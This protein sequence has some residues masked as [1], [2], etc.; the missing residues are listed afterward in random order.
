MR[1]VTYEKTFGKK[2]ST[3][4]L[5][6]LIHHKARLKSS[7]N[8]AHRKAHLA[9]YTETYEICSIPLDRSAIPGATRWP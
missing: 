8:R 9:H 5:R 4:R 6:D 1:V 7:R 3:A 2:A